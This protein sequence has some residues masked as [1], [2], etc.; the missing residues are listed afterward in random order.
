M[1]MVRRI[2]APE[3]HQVHDQVDEQNHKRKDKGKDHCQYSKYIPHRIKC[4]TRC[5]SHHEHTKH[6]DHRENS[7]RHTR[8]NASASRPGLL[9]RHQWQATLYIPMRLLWRDI[10]SLRRNRSSVCSRW[11]LDIVVLIGIVRLRAIAK[12][13]FKLGM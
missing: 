11:L 6:K 4:G 8:A 9:N 12:L 1:Q 7:Q 3:A 13:F 10:S 2:L 5:Q